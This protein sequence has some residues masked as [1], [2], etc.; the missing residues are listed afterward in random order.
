M[1]QE[2]GGSFAMLGRIENGHWT[3]LPELSGL[4][5]I[6]G[7]RC[8]TD[9]KCLGWYEGWASKDAV[10]GCPCG[11]GSQGA[12]LSGD[13]VSHRC[14]RVESTQPVLGKRSEG[15]STCTKSQKSGRL[16]RIPSGH[17]GQGEKMGRRWR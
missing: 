10:V 7:I 13:K 6:D 15:W 4:R 5:E 2:T 16:G 9:R 1:R 8:L 11:F 3:E 17:A 12:L 14:R